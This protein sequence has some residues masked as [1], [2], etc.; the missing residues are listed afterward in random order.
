MSDDFKLQVNYKIGNDLINIR[1]STAEELSMHLEGLAEVSGQIASTRVALEQVR[2][3]APL[4][5]GVFTPQAVVTN[6]Q[7]D[8]PVWATTPPPAPFSGPVGNTGQPTP[9]PV[10]Q[11]TPTCVHGNRIHRSGTSKK[12]GQPYSFWACPTPQGT[13]DQC[14]PAN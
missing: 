13:P 7:M 12:T 4:S 11:A 1:A 10:V 9:P 3:I 8:E 6:S 2:I 5:T 14:K